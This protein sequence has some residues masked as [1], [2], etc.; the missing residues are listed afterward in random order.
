MPGYAYINR[1]LNMSRIC[2]DIIYIAY[3]YAKILNMASSEYDRVLN[4]LEL[5][6]VL[7]IPEYVLFP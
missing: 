2:Q 3:K 7:D 5:Q 4:M 1:I 6:S